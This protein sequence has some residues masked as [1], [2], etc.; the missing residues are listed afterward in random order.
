MNPIIK[1]LTSKAEA[2]LQCIQTA[3]YLMIDQKHYKKGY[4][5]PFLKC[6]RPRDRDY[7]LKEVHLGIW[8]NH[9]GYKAF[10]YKTL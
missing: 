1:Y 6:I 9:L 3:R 2:R 10:V 4:P 5:Q 7:F 8:G